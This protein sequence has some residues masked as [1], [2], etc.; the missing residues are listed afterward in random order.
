[1][2]PTVARRVR[3]SAVP[4]RLGVAVGRV[5]QG[6]WIRCEVDARPGPG[7]LPCIPQ[8]HVVLAASLHL[9]R[10]KIMLSD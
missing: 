7:R 10:S 1:V 5:G 2:G 3:P 6:R 9:G 4:M 8:G